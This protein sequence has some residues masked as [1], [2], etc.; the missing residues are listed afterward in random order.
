MGIISSGFAKAYRRRHEAILQEATALGGHLFG[1]DQHMQNASAGGLLG[2]AL[3]AKVPLAGA[4]ADGVQIFG[5]ET[6][7]VRHLYVQP[8]SGM[9]TL[10][11]EHH[12]WLTGS[13][14]SPIA[15]RAG[16]L[17][18]KWHAGGDDEL[19]GWL[20]GQAALRELV[21][22]C[23]TTWK[24][25]TSSFDL[26]W[27][28][29]LMS[30]GDGRSHLVMNAGSYGGMF[31]TQVGA[32]HFLAL[33]QTLASLLTQQTHPAQ[34]PLEQVGYTDAFH[35]YLLGTPSVP[36]QPQSPATQPEYGVATREY[37]HI[38]QA[39]RPFDSDTFLVGMLPEDVEENVR[40]LILPPHQ[41]QTAICVVLDLTAFGSAKDAVVITPTYLYARDLGETLGFAFADLASADPPKG[42]MSKSVKVTLRSGRTLKVP[43]GDE[44]EALHAVLTSLC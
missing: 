18:F 32:R 36:C 14:R 9:N 2:H 13:Y 37:E 11:G 35:R 27:T 25:G 19:R 38:M 44:G 41:S 28:V 7:G 22:A 15:F 6:A 21:K 1:Y 42:I 31:G 26:D 12:A 23:A 33:G 8:W 3:R 17:G 29:Q 5:F 20:E 40:S 10:P 4:K 30:M 43:C 34:S 39:A 16:V 24:S